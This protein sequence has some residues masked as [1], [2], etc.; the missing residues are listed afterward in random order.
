MFIVRNLWAGRRGGV[1]GRPEG[2]VDHGAT[3]IAAASRGV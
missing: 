2:A 1:P 3:A